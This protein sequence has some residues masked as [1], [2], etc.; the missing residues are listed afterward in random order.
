MARTALTV[1]QIDSDGV[2]NSLSAANAD[3][4]SVVA[5]SASFLTVANGSGSSINVTIPS[6]NTVDGLA[7][8]DRVVAVAAGATTHIALNR[9]R[10]STQSNGTQSINFSAVTTV[11]CAAFKV[12]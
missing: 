5:G 12:A 9:P 10:N 8:A 6:T 4:H 7:V 1:Q 11:T 2:V 3:G